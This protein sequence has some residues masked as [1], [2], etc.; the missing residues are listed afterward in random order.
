MQLPLHTLFTILLFLTLQSP[1]SAFLNLSFLSPSPRAIGTSF[2]ADKPS[3]PKRHLSSSRRI[4]KPKRFGYFSFS[5][6]PK[7]LPDWDP[8]E[9]VEGV[10]IHRGIPYQAVTALKAESMAID[11][12]PNDD[13]A[14]D[15]DKEGELEERDD[16]DD[17]DAEEF[18]LEDCEKRQE[19]INLG[20]IPQEELNL[21]QSQEGIENNDQLNVDDSTDEGITRKHNDKILW[22]GLESLLPLEKGILKK[23]HSFQSGGGR[24]YHLGDEGDEGDYGSGRGR[25]GYGKHANEYDGGGGSGRG[26]HSSQDQGGW[27][28]SPQSHR[29]GN[30]NGKGRPSSGGWHRGGSGGG[31]DGKYQEDWE[32][33]YSSSSNN[34]HGY[35]SGRNDDDG[36]E[37]WHHG[38]GSG[39]KGNGNGN[40]KWDDGQYHTWKYNSNTDSDWNHHPSS[41]DWNDHPWHSPSNPKA[42]SDHGFSSQSSSND[43]R[44]DCMNLANFYKLA[45]QNGGEWLRHNGWSSTATNGDEVGDCCEWYGV[46]CDPISRRVTALNLRRNGLE[47]N[48]A[49]SLF[50]LDA[51]MR[52]DL[53][54]NTLSTL[55]DKFDS[56]PRLTHMNISSSSIPSSIPSSISTS[57]SL[58][59]LDLSNNELVGNV[60]LSASML[61]SVDLSNNRLTSFSISPN[62]MNTLSKVVLSNNEFRGEL[63]DLSGLRS[64]QSLDLSYNNTGPLFDISNLTNLTRLD[65]RSNQLTGSFAALPPSI[66]SLYLS[67]NQFTGPIPSLPSPKGLTSCYVLPNNFS[68]CP[69]KEDLSD[70][71]TLASKCHLKTCG[72]QQPTTTVSS[73]STSGGGTG[74]TIDASRVSVTTLPNSQK[75][76][77]VNPLP[78]ENLNNSQNGGRPVAGVSS[79]EWQGLKSKNQANQLPQTQRLGSNKLNSNGSNTMNTQGQYTIVVGLFVSY[80]LFHFGVL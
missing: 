42:E 59:N 2:K 16:D 46:T 18:M 73:S 4:T 79:N 51:L 63:P 65:V 8:L 21:A 30:M 15:E 45:Q 47:G 10:L 78:G 58:I 12:H 7:S 1:I 64:L 41:S 28:D 36:N 39:S 25:K 61:K 31:G 72:L 17:D 80:V 14:E 20:T 57:A 11:R 76:I 69:S 26:R 43:H 56:L 52:L 62:G 74:A 50:N 54:Q 13:A 60:H 49:R 67:S 23:R 32:R 55:P 40:G 66:Q 19:N 29:G 24:N 5:R 75:G 44:S 22:S 53:S 70:P 68:P 34:H 37:G 77:P 6:H 48:L 27:N 71:N 3:L 9:G 33:P 38:D 35:G